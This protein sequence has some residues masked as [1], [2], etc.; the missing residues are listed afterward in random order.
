MSTA[1]VLMG[2]GL[3]VLNRV[4]ASPLID[5]FGMRKQAEQLLYLAS[6]NAFRAAGAAG[7]QFAA[8]QKLA[9]PE[10]LAK[11]PP[12]GLFDL[13]PS[14]EQQM[15]KE[16]VLAFAGEQLRPAALAA[17]HACA[18]PSALLAQAAE[19]GIAAMG[20]PETLGGAGSERSAVT[21]ALVAEAMAQGDIGLAVA[22]LAP[23][24]VSTALVL[25]GDEGQ[26]AKY[27]PAFTG[28]TLPAAAL[29]IQEPR[30][31][32]NP[33]DLETTAKPGKRGYVLNGVKSLVPL[34]A[35]AELFIISAE[36]VGHGPALFIVEASTPGLIIDAEPAMGLRAAATGTLKLDNVILSG[37]AMLARGSQDAYAECI[38]LSRIAWSAL[39]VG[40]AQAALDYLIPYVNERVAF[41]EPISHRQSVAFN[42]ANIGIELEGMRLAMLR[43]ASRAEQGLDFAREA[44]IARKLATDKGMQIGSDAVQLLGGHGFVKEH[45]AERWY[46]DLRAVGVMEGVVLV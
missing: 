25:W 21:N 43:A 37:D 39:A 14:D 45:P 15:L 10:R 18:A 8:V 38:A 11:V 44:A 24:A 26:Q 22:C 30:A 33:F 34:A 23:T 1:D 13:T 19:L 40:G 31:L 4:S 42:I 6:K 9:K 5:R 3:R 27:L 17:D 36:L 12:R 35:T 28:E 20:I 41:G 16:A 2:R 7:R 46:R 32:F 29:A